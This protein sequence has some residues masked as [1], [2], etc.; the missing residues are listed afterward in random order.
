MLRHTRASGWYKDDVPIET[1][2]IILGHADA[3]TT[4]KSYASPSVEM[5][6]DNMRSG[7][8]VEPEVLDEKENHCGRMMRN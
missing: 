6:R 1:I 5:L 8:D 7:T 2:A 3:K 4:R